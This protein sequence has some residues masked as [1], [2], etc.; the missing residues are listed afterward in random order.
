[1]I[2]NHHAV[3]QQ[4]P[5]EDFDGFQIPLLLQV[6]FS[7][8][9]SVEAIGVIVHGKQSLSACIS[10]GEVEEKIAYVKVQDFLR[11]LHLFLKWCS[12]QWQP[13]KVAIQKCFL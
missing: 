2:Q 13:K 7:L 1:M 10:Q 3:T 12:K 5:L 4:L 11:S 9:P 6:D 8:L